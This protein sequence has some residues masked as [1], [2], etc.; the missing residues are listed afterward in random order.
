M[1]DGFAVE[2]TTSRCG[3][4]EGGSRWGSASK[5]IIRATWTR[6]STRAAGTSHKAESSEVM[7]EDAAQAGAW[8][9]SRQAA[10]RRSI[11]LACSAGDDRTEMLPIQCSCERGQRRGEKSRRGGA[12]PQTRPIAHTVGSLMH[13]HVPRPARKRLLSRDIK[14]SLAGGTAAGDAVIAAVAVSATTA[15][16]LP[17]GALLPP[18]P[19]PL[20]PLQHPPSACAMDHRH[21]EAPRSAPSP[22]FQPESPGIEAERAVER[23]A[24]KQKILDAC[25][26]RDLPLLAALSC[27]R[28]GL[29]D[30]EAR[31]LA[32]MLA[33]SALVSVDLLM[34][35]SR[36][37]A[38]WSGKPTR[39]PHPP[40]DGLTTSSGRGPESEKSLDGRK[41]ELDDL[42][43]DVLRR[44]PALCYFQGFHDIVQVLLLVLGRQDATPAVARLSLLRIRDFM[45]PSMTAAVVHLQLLPSILRAADATLE[46][47]LSS[48]RPFFA[49]AATLTLYAHDIEEYGDIARLFDFLLSR[50]SVI[51]LYLF[52][53]DELLD[54]EPDEPEMLHSVLSKLPQPLDLEGLIAKTTLLYDQ[55]P[56]HK[57]PGTSWA[58]VSSNSV[59]KTTLD[60]RV[61][62]GQSLHDGQ[63]YFDKQAAEIRRLEFLR[64]VQSRLWQYRRPAAAF[65]VAFAVAVLSYWLRNNPAILRTPVS[66]APRPKKEPNEPGPTSTSNGFISVQLIAYAKMANRGYDV[67]VDVDQEFFDVDT[68]EVL[69]RCA[70]A[71]FPRANFLDVLDGN[72]DLYGPFWLATTV[73]VILFLTGSVSRWLQSAGQPGYAYDFRLLSGAAGLVYGYTG[74]GC[75]CARVLGVVWVCECDLDPGGADQLESAG[76]AQLGVCGGGAG[77]QRAVPRAQLVAGHQ[78]DAASACEG[79]ARAGCAAACRVGGHHQVSVLCVSLSFCGILVRGTSG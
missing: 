64:S 34:A 17:V 40:F 20:P 33:S 6:R 76:R 79:V 1:V 67:V 22:E 18:E 35:A 5:V 71:V 44:H 58:K 3:G 51:S 14:T 36:A 28:W 29:I 25:L 52:A 13:A 70:A 62:A 72:P 65:A 75:E 30:D 61:L 59:L 42:I 63:S 11:G 2:R 74:R 66:P 31:R 73:V 24:K 7:G 15:S 21:D 60:P 12:A 55:H 32:C 9:V 53:V 50:E 46:R 16:A 8:A 10:G 43:T 4:A 77:G 57:L 69:R 37:S 26:R 48:T 38:T 23:A 41:E 45:L 56:P 19:P 49:L 47:H 68:H 27:S 54:I 78:H 39:A